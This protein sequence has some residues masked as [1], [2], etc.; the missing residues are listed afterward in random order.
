M[1]TQTVTGVTTRSKSR[2]AR[3]AST[4]AYRSPWTLGSF[5]TANPGGLR[6]Q[7]PPAREEG[8]ESRGRSPGTSRAFLS[9]EN[10]EPTE[11]L[12]DYFT[13]EGSHAANLDKDE[14]IRQNLTNVSFTNLPE[15]QIE[16]Y[17]RIMDQ[18]IQ[19][20]KAET[21]EDFATQ[22]RLKRRRNLSLKRRQEYLRLLQDREE[23][24]VRKQQ[25]TPYEGKGKKPSLP[26]WD[27]SSIRSGGPVNQR[28]QP[29]GRLPQE[30]QRNRNFG[31]GPPDE[32]PDDFESDHGSDGSDHDSE[33]TDRRPQGRNNGGRNELVNFQLNNFRA[34]PPGKFDP[35]GKTPVKEWLFKMEIWFQAA[36]IPNNMKVTQAATLLE[37]HAFTWWMSKNRDGN[38]PNTWTRFSTELVRQFDSINASVKARRKI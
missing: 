35:K 2:S 22:A 34:S 9:P 14:A 31:S 7:S 18:E 37:G 4:G 15:D 10:P 11:D 25:E 30:P 28:N 12:G 20:I 17:Q 24:T 33:E 5:S 21:A 8:S 23:Q 1:A 32:D 27:V 26:N 36:S 13:D 19:R 16:N 29:E 38:I 6:I 3:P